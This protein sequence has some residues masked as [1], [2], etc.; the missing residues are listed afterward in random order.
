MVTRGR[1][2]KARISDKVSNFKSPG[3]KSHAPKTT[4]LI[5]HLKF[6]FTLDNKIEEYES[7]EISTFSTT[8]TMRCA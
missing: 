7:F 4:D 6:V 8:K 2:N 5:L 3:H 1:K